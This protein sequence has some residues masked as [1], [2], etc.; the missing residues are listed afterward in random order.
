M[1]YINPILLRLTIKHILGVVNGKNLV[2]R[3]LDHPPTH[4]LFFN[5]Y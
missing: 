2:P 5:F 3:D 1:Y 4:L